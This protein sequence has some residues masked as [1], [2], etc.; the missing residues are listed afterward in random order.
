[1]AKWAIPVDWAGKS[2]MSWNS[3][4]LLR[5]NKTALILALLVHL[6]R[7]CTH[8]ANWD[9]F[10]VTQ[11]LS[12]MHSLTKN[13]NKL[14]LIDPSRII[15]VQNVKQEILTGGYADGTKS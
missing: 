8:L 15:A 9:L 11:T 14:L 10:S 5:Q 2:Q 7:F 3:H 4:T 1:M 6:T 13:G 12:Q